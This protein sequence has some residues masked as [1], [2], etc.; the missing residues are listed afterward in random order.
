MNKS[1]AFQE[2]LLIYKYLCIERIVYLLINNKQTMANVL[3][4]VQNL[5]KSFE[6]WELMDIHL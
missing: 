4:F 5:I 1:F 6:Q 3:M 2:I